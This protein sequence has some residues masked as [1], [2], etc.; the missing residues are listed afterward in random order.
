MTTQT[1]GVK[2]V[3]VLLA[4]A[5]AACGD[6]DGAG[7]ADAAAPDG[8][9]ADA[10][11]AAVLSGTIRSAGET[12]TA[13]AG[14]TITVLGT[15]TTVTADA[16]G[17]YSLEVPPGTVQLLAE[18]DE[19]WSNIFTVTHGAG[20]TTDVDFEVIPNQLVAN[21]SAALK[22]EIDA[23]EGVVFVRFATGFAGGGES[24]SVP[25]AGGAFTFDAE[26]QANEGNSLVSGGDPFVIH[27]GVPPGR[28]TVTVDGSSGVNECVLDFPDVT[29]WPVRAATFTTVHATCTA[30]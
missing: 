3:A 19:H 16:Q 2:V 15:G 23:A 4:I 5:A 18:Q 20:G 13:A 11:P 25:G 26:G 17:F 9:G 12:P 1:M 29:D 22:T 28:A 8:G 10:G 24:A 27:H 6:D 21:A 30:I 7:T 14:A